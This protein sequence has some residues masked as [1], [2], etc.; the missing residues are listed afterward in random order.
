MKQ[1]TQTVKLYD[2]GHV[3]NAAKSI[4]RVPSSVGTGVGACGFS[5]GAPA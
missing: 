4:T 2:L 3:R 5:P 1:S